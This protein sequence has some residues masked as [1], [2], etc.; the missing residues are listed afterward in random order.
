MNSILERI[1]IEMGKIWDNQ[2][3]TDLWL[4]GFCNGLYP[5][6]ANHPWIMSYHPKPDSPL[7]FGTFPQD[8][9]KKYNKMSLNGA[10][11]F[12]KSLIF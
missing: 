3:W 7:A 5:A 2:T 9:K 6:D 1:R 8:C 11:I 10:K 12:I 4:F